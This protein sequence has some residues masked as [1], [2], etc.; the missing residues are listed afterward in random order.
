[1]C[2]LRYTPRLRPSASM[3]A[4]ELKKT[5]PARSKKLMGSTTPSSR[6]TSLKYRTARF[7]STL[8]A[9]FKCRLSCSMQKYGASNN[10]GSRMICAPRA[11]ASRTSLCAFAILPAASQSQDIWMAA[12]VTWRG[13]RRKC[14]GS[15]DIDDLSGIEYA[16]RI[17]GGLEG[18]HGRNFGTRPRDFKIGLSLEPDPMLGRDGAG[19]AAQRLVHTSLDRVEGRS[20]PLGVADAHGDMQIA[21][22]NVSKHELPRTGHPLVQRAPHRFEI[23]RHVGDGE[24]HIEAV[25]RPVAIH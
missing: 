6:A 12:T 14:S 5:G 1:M 17:E 22:R 2:D 15:V 8:H 3:I 11:A 25:R 9:R 18:P 7:S 13:L 10:S 4:I 24:T 21:I 16:A 19:N 20:M 23:A